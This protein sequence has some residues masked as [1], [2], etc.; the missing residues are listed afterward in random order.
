M[1]GEESDA[2]PSRDRKRIALILGCLL[3]TVA[4]ALLLPTFATDGLAGSPIDRA[5]P[6]DET[7]GEYSDSGG[8]DGGLGAL[9]PGDTTG[10]GGEIGLDSDTFGNTDTELHFTVRSTTG[11]YWRTGA[12]DVYTGDGWERNTDTTPLDGSIEHDGIR[13]ERIEYE[14]EFETDASAIPT[15]WRPT[16]VEGVDGLQVTDA[17]AIHSET[18][19][20]SGTTISGVS[21]APERDVGMLRSQSGTYPSHVEERFTQL[22]DET[23]SRVEEV[24]S[25]ITAEADG[26]YEA[27]V[28]IEDWLQSEKEYDL[29]AS[30]ESENIADTFIFEM[31]RGYCEYFATAMVAMLR[32]Q[33]IPSRY[34][35][36]YSTG[37]YVGNE[38]YEVRAMNAHAWVEVYFEDVGWVRFD[39]TPGEERLS[40]Q[41]EALE[42]IS[43]EPTLRDTGSPGEEIEPGNDVEETTPSEEGVHISLNR[44]AVPGKSVE[45]TVTWFGNPYP[46]TPV[47]FNDQE[48]G[49]TDEEGVMVATVPDVDE[50]TVAVDPVRIDPDPVD[51]EIDPENNG[52]WNGAN[53]SQASANG[54]EFFSSGGGFIAD[55]G[56]FLAGSSGFDGVST[57]QLVLEETGQDREEETFPVERDA[58]IAVTGEKEPGASV[59]LTVRVGDI[60]IRDAPITVD[61]EEVGTTNGDGQLE[62]SL[63][64]TTGDVSIQV[65]DGP[66]TG[67]QTVTIP[68]LEL[69]VDTGTLPPM[70]LGSV[71]V[72]ATIGGEPASGVPISIGG[73]EV[74][75]TG[76][77]GTA[78]VSLPL[79]HEAVLSVSAAGQHEQTVLSGLLFP[80]GAIVAIAVPS[81]GGSILL[82]KRRGYSFHRWLV[83]GRSI[84]GALT[85]FVVGALVVAASRGDEFLLAVH[86]RVRNLFAGLFAVATGKK[87]F[88]EVRSQIRSTGA[89]IRRRSR[90]VI[91]LLRDRNPPEASA[92]QVST[93][94]SAWRRFLDQLS[95]SAPETRTPGEL[96]TYAIENEGLPEEQVRTLR[97]TFREVEYGPGSETDRIEDLQV[98]IEE[99]E[100]ASMQGREQGETE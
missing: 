45:V 29:R 66:I 82:L 84:P 80:L 97:D 16:V 4:T 90:N 76:T 38:T 86:S 60:L 53:N 52:T 15:P 10:V 8:G 25:Q 27:A 46:E 30:R 17:G 54:G 92:E 71:T 59:L 98:A 63:P 93:V 1:D 48:I 31:N 77:A 51:V 79:T 87:Q 49:E 67:S 64:E 91:H 70:A 96:A 35:V 40:A 89:S 68:E 65:E 13:D 41:E 7:T 78:T 94:E 11:T 9:H 85:R 3:V 88:A 62:I 56:K 34:V 95:I 26:P 73:E 75:T 72:E 18:V 32:S 99:V 22:P 58:T 21:Y 23:P 14:L 36:G 100:R 24:T 55:T 83:I 2:S 20:E 28:A 37:E 42:G 5:L 43:D 33:D 74:A 44:T 47:Y 61:G 81:L 6:G 19:I 57:D 12:Y 69:A 39:P 50:L